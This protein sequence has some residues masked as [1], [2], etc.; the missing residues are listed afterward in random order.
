MVRLYDMVEAAQIDADDITIHGLHLGPQKMSTVVVAPGA[1]VYPVPLKAN[2]AGRLVAVSDV[3]SN[4]AWKSTASVIVPGRTNQRASLTS[5]N[6][7]ELQ[8]F[9]AGAN[10]FAFTADL[11]PVGNANTN[12]PVT[13]ATPFSVQ[14]AVSNCSQACNV[15]VTLT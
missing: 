13:D 15:Y 11:Q 1:N 10:T 6:K 7:S 9:A 5:V 4:A 2:T 3:F 8:G 12:A 14:L